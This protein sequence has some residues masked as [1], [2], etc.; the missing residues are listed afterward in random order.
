MQHRESNNENAGI[1]AMSYLMLFIGTKSLAVV[2]S[3]L[4]GHGTFGSEVLWTMLKTRRSFCRASCEAL[5][6]KF[7]E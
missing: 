4:G 7:R 1:V 5:T 3:V 2:S 6:E